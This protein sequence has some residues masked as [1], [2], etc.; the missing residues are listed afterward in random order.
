MRILGRSVAPLQLRG[1]QMWLQLKTLSHALILQHAPRN[2]Y[3]SWLQIRFAT[4][5]FLTILQAVNLSCA[6]GGMAIAFPAGIISREVRATH[7][8]TGEDGQ[9][10]EGIAAIALDQKLHCRRFARIRSRLGNR[11]RCQELSIWS[12]RGGGGEQLGET[13][14]DMT[15]PSETRSFDWLSS[16]MDSHPRRHATLLVGIDGPGGVVIVEG[17]YS[18][19]DE[20]VAWYDFTIWL[21]CPRE[22]RLARGIAR[23]G[24][25]IREIWEQDWMVAEDLYI[26][27]QHPQLRADL[28]IDSSGQVEHDP[29][30]EFI[31]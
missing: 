28:L 18:T 30:T 19:R 8:G 11:S 26:Q 5:V 13:E 20:L 15:M 14:Y 10:L 25:S 29:S 27:H 22:T 12:P 1:G 9:D 24:E 16:L 17:V 6:P 7:A 4:L 2:P 31:C 23:S 3:Y 21:E